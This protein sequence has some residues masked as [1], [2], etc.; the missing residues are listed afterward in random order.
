[1]SFMLANVDKKASDMASILQAAM[2]P[3]RRGLL[4][5]GI[6]EEEQCEPKAIQRTDTDLSPTQIGTSVFFSK[7]LTIQL[8]PLGQRSGHLG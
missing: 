6:G 7:K 8:F 3:P 5:P 2:A 4:E 1:M